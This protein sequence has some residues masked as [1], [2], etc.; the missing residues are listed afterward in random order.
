MTGTPIDNMH[1]WQNYLS[2]TFDQPTELDRA[3]IERRIGYRL[4]ES[5]WQLVVREQGRSPQEASIDLPVE[6]E[7]MFGILLLVLAGDRLQVEA[8][9][10]VER[11]LDNMQ[12]FYPNGIVPFADDTGGNYWAFDFRRNPATPSI[13]FVDHEIDGEDGLTR[14]AGSFDD[15]IARMG[16]AG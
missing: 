1:K 12:D 3:R 15:F 9:Y 16:I 10:S 2:K 8:S 6:G 4:P 11:S 7:V 14:A 13:V 5:Y